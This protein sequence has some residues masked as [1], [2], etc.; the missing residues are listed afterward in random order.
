MAHLGKHDFRV[1]YGGI[2]KNVSVA[3]YSKVNYKCKSRNEI[4]YSLR[5]PSVC[6][7]FICVAAS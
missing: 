1:E 2:S 3:V 4:V 7:V 5:G 6:F